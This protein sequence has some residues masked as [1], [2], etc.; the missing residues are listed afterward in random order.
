MIE[1]SGLSIHQGD[2]VLDDVSFVVPSGEY[3]VLMGRS[4]CGKSSV[5]EAVCGLRAHRAG[6]IRLDGCDV[7]HK[8][9]GERGVGYVPQDRALFPGVVVR[10]QIAFSLIIRRESVAAIAKRVDELA[11]LLGIPH[12][13]D[14]EPENLSGG[15]AQRVA[16]ARA[17]AFRPSVLC[18]DE[19]LSALDEST[20]DEICG[21]LA[22]VQQRTHVTVLH[23]TH[24][25][26]EAQRLGTCLL[27]FDEGKIR[28]VS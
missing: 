18:L 9:P 25:R 22:G 3:G 10:R 20:L 13:L 12:I 14:R 7:T 26:R 17:L 15:E 28:P 27:E 6:V 19:P 11:E 16:L 5:L 2:F 1:V 21:L 8:R 4:G 24:G 23:V